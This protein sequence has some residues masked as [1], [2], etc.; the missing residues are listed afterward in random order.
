[1]KRILSLIL[2]VV[3]MA[4]LVLAVSPAPAASGEKLV[5]LTL[6]LFAQRRFICLQFFF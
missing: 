5:A 3:W 4:G 2:A 1:M 6:L